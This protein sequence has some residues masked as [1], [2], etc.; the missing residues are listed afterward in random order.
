MIQAILWNLHH[1]L[2]FLIHQGTINKLSIKTY[3]CVKIDQIIKIGKYMLWIIILTH[4]VCCLCS[5]FNR[6]SPQVGS[7]PPQ[8]IT[9]SSLKCI[10]FM[11]QFCYS[12]FRYMQYM[13]ENNCSISVFSMILPQFRGRSTFVDDILN[14]WIYFI[15]EHIRLCVK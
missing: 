6:T 15:S 7:Q 2:I 3:I 11:Q 12:L 1:I 9:Y 5:P 10:Y 8:D 13:N 14:V 4:V